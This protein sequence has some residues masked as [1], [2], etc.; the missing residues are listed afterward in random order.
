MSAVAVTFDPTRDKAYRDTGLGRDVADFL[1]WMEL[2]GTSP[3]TADQYERDLARGCLM[4]PDLSIREWTDS[5]LL[6]VMRRF[7]PAERRVR[8][9]AWRSFFRWARQTK[10]IRE[11]PME[12]LPA[13]KQPAQKVIDVFS[14]AEVEALLSLDVVDAA[15]LG[16][17]LEAGLRKAEACGLQFSRCQPERQR[18]TVLEGKGKRD[19]VIPMSARLQQLL[20]DL[21]I[22]EG[23]APTDHIF[24]RVHANDVS[25]QRKRDKRVGEGTFHRW[26]GRCLE[27]A[28]VRYRKPHTAR[29][30][31]ATRL[32][33]IG[34][35]SEEIQLLLGHASVA[36]TSDIYVHT[37]VEDVAARMQELMA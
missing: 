26:W 22:I 10:R 21:A 2:G 1:A 33:K 37:R 24:Y 6:H 7:K 25:S 17:L 14:D 19:R 32:Y 4:F 5:E 36:T 13:I 12:T 35:R 28:C 18:V 16:I 29:H 20:A 15:P 23:L 3:R 30:T 34:L 9:A 31:F 8:M 11:N 27:Q